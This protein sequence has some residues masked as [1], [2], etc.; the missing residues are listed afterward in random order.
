LGREAQVA[1]VTVQTAQ[2]VLH[3]HLIVLPPQA[4]AE[5]EGLLRRAKMAG[6]VVAREA[7]QRHPIQAELETLLPFPQVKEAMAVL[8]RL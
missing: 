4:A 6:Q 7:R 1:L 2:L 8:V 3:Q 5:V